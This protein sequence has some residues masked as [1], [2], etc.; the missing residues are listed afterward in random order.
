[1]TVELRHLRCFLAIAEEANITRAAARLHLGQPALSRTLR[2]LE[3]HLG[4]RLVDRSTHHLHL[5]EAGH[6]FRTRALT[7]V[8]AVDDALDPTRVGT[9]PLRL[10]HAWAALGDHTTALLRRWRE[11]HPE[12][13]LE[14]LRITDATAGLD[15]GKTD[16]ALVRG[17]VSGPR[18]LLLAEP[19]LAAVP[20]GSDLAGR[21]AL[22]LADLTDQVIVLNPPTGTTTTALWPAAIRPS[23][24]VVVAN[25]DDWLAAI[26]SG[27]G[28]GVTTAGTAGIHA[29]PGVAYVPLT[30]APPVPVHLV[31]TDPPRHPAI[32]DLLALARDVV[33]G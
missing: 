6:A 15:Q 18:A 9:W 24:T 5:T 8:A 2:Q 7:A 32:P 28:V 20:T 12:T 11:T 22:A 23:T 16:V 25:T 3:E 17:P 27:R 1:M 29:Y 26:A 4:V 31:W 14:L 19:R 30:D 10:G 21:P 33:G 13:P